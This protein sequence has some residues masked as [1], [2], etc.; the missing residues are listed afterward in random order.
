MQE[1]SNF[2][3]N[4]ARKQKKQL[5]AAQLVGAMQQLSNQVKLCQDAIREMES[6]VSKL[7]VY[8]AVTPEKIMQEP[9]ENPTAI[10][11]DGTYGAAEVKSE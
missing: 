9:E 11:P 2:A 3:S 6:F 1:M 8:L 7:C 4:I 5:A 10:Q